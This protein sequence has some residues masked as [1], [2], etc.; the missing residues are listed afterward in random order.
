MNN[1]TDTDTMERERRAE[2][3]RRWL[4]KL[5][6]AVLTVEYDGYA[7]SGAIEEVAAHTADNQPI[8]LPKSLKSKLIDLFYDLL[9]TRFYGWENDSGAFGQFK[10]DLRTNTVH[11]IHNDRYEDY[12]TTERYGWSVPGYG[13]SVS[14]KEGT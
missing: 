3:M 7:D 14:G 1:T 2:H 13:W 9:E 6:V 10:W 5:G 4:Q 12:D 8:A 11:Q